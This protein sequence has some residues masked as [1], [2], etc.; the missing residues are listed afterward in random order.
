MKPAIEALCGRSGMLSRS[1]ISSKWSMQRIPARKLSENKKVRDQNVL[2]VPS[3]L[4]AVGFFNDLDFL[5]P[6]FRP[7]LH[8]LHMP[9]DLRDKKDHFELL[10]D[11]PGCEKNDIHVHVNKS[12]LTVSAERH[13]KDE[14][15][16]EGDRHIRRERHNH[17]SRS[18]T[19]PASVV[20][21]KIDAHYE[22]GVL[23]VSMPK[24]PEDTKD[25][26]RTIPLK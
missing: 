1:F 12:R 6:P 25:L 11:L 5:A 23:T 2:A 19:I 9:L 15:Q 8:F 18:I 26:S 16:D 17:F 4:D 24:N 21:D 13:I 10:V 20:K 22:N 3:S 7:D 14:K